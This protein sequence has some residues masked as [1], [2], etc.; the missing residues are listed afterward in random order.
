MARLS[1]EFIAEVE[2]RAFNRW[3]EILESL[4][5]ELGPAIG[6][7]GK[8]VACPH[9]A[10]KAKKP[11]GLRAFFKHTAKGTTKE[12]GGMVCNTCGVFANGFST[13]MWARGWTFPGAVEAV[14][15]WLGGVSKPRTPEE[16][17]ADARRRAQAEAKARRETARLD[18]F[19]RRILNEV[20]KGTVRL[21]HPSAAPG[22]LYLHNRGITAP[23]YSPA[24]R[25]HPALEYRD[26]NGTVIDRLP[27]IVLRFDTS[28]WKPG[29][30]HRIYTTSHG[31]KLEELD[32]RKKMMPHPSD[33]EL[34]GG[35]IRL[36]APSETLGVTEG[37]ENAEAVMALFPVNC[38]S[39]Y[40][41]TL[42]ESFVPPMGVKRV[43]IFADR[44]ASGAGEKSARI[45]LERLW[46]LGIKAEI[47]LPPI[48][49]PDGSKGVD[50]LDFLNFRAS[51]Q[52]RPRCS[53]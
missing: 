5:P 49:I 2:Q 31:A 28:D 11:N 41:R 53:A 44:D 39:L 8:G 25:F 38:W 36:T 3:D 7:R 17:A 29:T 18:K 12:T 50:W 42:M 13:L 37:Y 30:L 47:R 52:H 32:D 19:Y 9:H 34:S 22:R 23:H 16:I 14:A 6:A 35:A 45:L 24:V 27:A 48:P 20:L 43:I 33:R 26:D 10:S 51:R 40:S 15:D 4:A 1:K 21:D 46:A